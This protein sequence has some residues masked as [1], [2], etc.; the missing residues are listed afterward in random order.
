MGDMLKHLQAD[1]DN[2][3]TRT[4]S[5]AAESEEIEQ[6]KSINDTLRKQ[7]HDM[8]AEVG[9][10]RATVDRLQPELRRQNSRVRGL[11]ADVETLGEDKRTLACSLEEN[12]KVQK[13]AKTQY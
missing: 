5:S 8:A 11:T 7:V 12:A 1:L 2:A 4:F 9:A 6:L 10:L 13:E 3:R